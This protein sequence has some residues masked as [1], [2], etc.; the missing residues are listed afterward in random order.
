MPDSLKKE[1][2]KGAR[3][4][5]LGVLGKLAGPAFLVLVIRLYGPDNFGVYVTALA[6]VEMALAFL[7]AGF[8]D[9][10]VIFVARYAAED[11]GDPR[12]Y[13][14]LANAVIW[15]LVLAVFLIL[16]AMTLGP[17]FLPD[18]YADFGSELAAMVSLMALALPG[19]AFERVVVSATQ[20]LKIMKYEVIVNGMMRPLL[21]IA[22]ASAAYGVLPDYR[23]LAAA[24]L[25]TQIIIGLYAAFVFHRELAW[26]SL[27][28]AFRDF[29]IDTEMITFALPQNINAMFSRF[30]TNIDI[31]MLGM[32]G[33]SA[34]TTGLYAAG[35]MIVRE[36]RQLKLVF[37][38]SF[39]PHISELFEKKELDKLAHLFSTTVRWTTSLMI[40]VVLA[41]ASLRTDLLS[42]AHPDF[43]DSSAFFMIA[44]LPIPLLQG[45]LGFAG[46]VVVMSGFSRLNLYNSVAATTVNV[47]LNFFLIPSFGLAGAAIASTLAA[48]MKTAVEYIQMESIL[49]IRPRFREYFHPFAAGVP[50][51]ILMAALL[52]FDWIPSDILMGRVS[53]TLITVAV[54]T[55]LF[56]YFTGGTPWT[57][58]SQADS[59]LDGSEG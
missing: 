23:G 7:I 24:Y 34:G 9:G 30:V 57:R 51:A 15:S 53:I 22:F 25:A 38:T 26:K 2:G 8:K 44:L 54:Y 40:P 20:G 32:F 36:L 56:A 50:A 43:A 35:A 12:L 27:F 13:R 29:E 59:D 17:R 11:R 6:L 4:N 5:A 58:R 55:G 49:N 39:A 16:A 48:S 42:I 21:L 31:L 45:S 33:L 46:N 19:L 47:V 37:S 10:A 1:I 52:L 28:R 14:A 41:V 3:V 18:L